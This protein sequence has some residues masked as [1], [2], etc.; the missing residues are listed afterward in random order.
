MVSVIVLSFVVI[1]FNNLRLR[2]CAVAA[3]PA[4]RCAKPMASRAA[5]YTTGW[6]ATDL[7]DLSLSQAVEYLT[8]VQFIHCPA[9]ACK[10]FCREG[11]SRAL[12]LSLC[13]FSKGDP[14]S[15]KAVSRA[16]QPTVS[17]LVV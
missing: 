13:P 11:K 16:V 7:T 12:K 2:R 9:G 15:M 10:T 6:D 8:V 14:G 3:S 1:G 4:A 17:L 5:S